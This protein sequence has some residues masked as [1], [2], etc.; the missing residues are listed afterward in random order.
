VA[1]RAGYPLYCGEWGVYHKTPE[2]ARLA[3]YR[4]MLRLFHKYH[5]ANANWDYKGGFGPV[6]RN[7]QP[8]EIAEVLMQ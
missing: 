7:G 3:W 5:I 6:V 2:A 4:D 1:R 8:S